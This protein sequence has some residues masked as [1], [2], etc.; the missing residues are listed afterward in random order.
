[1]V[2]EG[3]KKAPLMKLTKEILDKNLVENYLKILKNDK[4]FFDIYD[5][6]TIGHEF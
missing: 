4:L 5:V 2:L 1:M 6:E 3:K